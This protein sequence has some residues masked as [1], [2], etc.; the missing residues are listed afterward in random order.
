MGTWE[1]FPYDFVDMDRVVAEAV[2]RYYFAR[3]PELVE[4]IV[5]EGESGI[6][7]LPLCEN[8]N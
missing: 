3:Y 1:L 8:L 7:Y 4:S 6:P 2:I 5:L